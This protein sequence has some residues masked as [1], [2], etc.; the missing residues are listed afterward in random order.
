[1]KMIEGKQTVRKHNRLIWIF[2]CIYFLI[3]SGFYL[4]KSVGEKQGLEYRFWVDA[5][6]RIW[7]W[8]LPL[9]GQGSDG[10]YYDAELGFC[11]GLYQS[12]DSGLNWEFVQNISVSRE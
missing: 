6:F 10:D 4:G 8:F 5:C 1:M 3:V 12:S 7:V 11:H 2:I 9:V